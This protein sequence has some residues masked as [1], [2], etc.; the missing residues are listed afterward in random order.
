MWRFHCI[1]ERET[2][3]KPVMCLR[4]T[5][6]HNCVRLSIY[7]RRN[8]DFQKSFTSGG[9]KLAEECL[10]VAATSPCGFSSSTSKPFLRARLF[11]RAAFIWDR[12]NG[13]SASQRSAWF[14]HPCHSEY[15]D[16]CPTSTLVN[17]EP[18]LPAFLKGAA[19]QALRSN[20]ILVPVLNN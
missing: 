18:F 12:T 4:P 6:S 19:H 3:A 11:D 17:T 15:S 16:S 7:L 14:D 13:M 1:F 20:I 2:T 8:N 5:K 9:L 10:H